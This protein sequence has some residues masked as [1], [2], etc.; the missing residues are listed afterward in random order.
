[1]IQ[2]HPAR[3]ASIHPT[4]SLLL[5]LCFVALC[6]AC[7]ASAAKLRVK[8]LRVNLVALNT[9]RDATLAF[10]K[11]REQQLYAACN[12]PTCTKEE[13]YATVDAFQKKVDVVITAL[14]L[15][16]RAVHDAGLLADA[17]SASEAGAAAARALTLYEELMKEKEKKP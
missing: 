16:Y 2:R 1:M 3:R 13:G 10:S 7:G 17:K 5:L 15:A 12:P 8:A 4:K 14:D 11:E 9:A 6:S